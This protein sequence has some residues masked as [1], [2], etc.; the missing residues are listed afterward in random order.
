MQLVGNIIFQK[1]FELSELNRDAKPHK[2]SR[3]AVDLKSM[4]EEDPA[5]IYQVR[6]GYKQ[7]YS[8]YNCN[9]NNSGDANAETNIAVLQNDDPDAPIESFWNN[10]VSHYE[11]YTWEHRKDPCFPAYYHAGNFARRNILASNIGMLAKRGN[12]GSLQIIVND[13]RSTQSIAEVN[14]TLYDFAQQKIG[15]ALTN[16]QGV[17]KFDIKKEPFVAVAYFQQ[18]RGYLKIQDGGN[19]SLSRFDV[20]GVAPQKGMKGYIYGERGVWRPGDSLYLNF[21]LEDKTGRLPADH[22]VSFKLKD[23]RG[24][25]QKS[26]VSSTNVK[27]VYPLH[28]ATSTEDP[29]GNWLA[30]VELGGATFTKS[31]KI[32][33]VKPNRLKIKLDFGKETLGP[34]DQNLS[35]DLQV[36]WLHGAPAKNLKA[37]IESKMKSIKTTFPTYSSFVFDDPAR[38]FD[39]E[40]KVIFDGT[41]NDK[42]TAPISTKLHQNTVAP[43]KLKIA[44][45]SRA[46]EQGGDFS[47]DNF[48]M[49]YSPY[50]RYAG[51]E[52]PVNQ[53]NSKRLDFGK[54]QSVD[55]VVVDSDGRPISNANLDVGLYRVEWRW[56]WDRDNNSENTQYNAADHKGSLVRKSVSTNSK[57]IAKF[58]FKVDDWGRYLIRACDDESG[59]CTG[60][61]FYAGYPWYDDDDNG[62]REAAAML[63]F[64]AGKKTYQMGEDIEIKIP[65]SENSRCLISI[66]NGTKVLK[67]IWKDAKAGDNIFKIPTTVDMTPNIYVNVTLLQA[68]GQNKND[69]GI[70]MYG[71][72][73]ITV[74][75]PA[76]KLDPKIQMPDVLEPKGKFT[77]KVSENNGQPMTYTVAVV[78]EGLLD[79]TRFK[80]PNPWN[81]FYAREALGVNTWDMYDLVLGAYGGDLKNILSIGG[82]GEVIDPNAAKK[83]NRFK[84]VVRHLGPFYLPAGE[85]ASHEITMPNY[86][87]SVRTMVVASGDLAY[88]KTEK[89]TAVK[90]PLMILATLPRVLGPTESLNLPVNVFAMEKHVKNVKISIKEL[91]GLGRFSGGTSQQL[92][93]N[94]IGDQIANFSLD[95]A[96][97]TGPAKFLVTATS[98]GESASQEIEI[99]IR[100]PNPPVTN[101]YDGTIAVGKNWEQSY[102]LAGMKGTNETILEVSGIPPLN[103]GK[104]LGYLLRYPHGCIEQTTSAAFPQL[105]VGK[106]L[107]MSTDDQDRAA[108]NIKAAISKINRYRRTDGSFSYWPGGSYYSDFGSNYAGHFLL[109]AQKAGYSV[110]ANLIADWRKSATKYARNWRFEAKENR[111]Y[112]RASNTLN[113]AY[114]LYTLALSGHPEWGAMNRLQEM[115]NLPTVA[116]WRL[117]LAYAEG[118]KPEIAKGLIRGLSKEVDAYQELGGSYGSEVRDEAMILETLV[119]INDKEA[120]AAVVR[121]LSENLSTDRWYST[122]TTAY[123]LLAIA[124]FV[125][126]NEVGKEIKFEYSLDGSPMVSAGSNSPIF[127]IALAEAGSKQSVKVVNSGRNLLFVRILQT[128]QPT[129]GDPTAVEKNLKMSIAYESMDGKKID[130]SRIEQGTDF[131]AKVKITHPGTRGIHYEEMALSQIFPSGWEIQNARLDAVGQSTNSD[132][133]YQ[134]IR[135]DRVFTY[136]DLNKNKSQTYQVQLNAAY[137]GKYYL[138]TVNCEAMYDQTVQARVPGRWVE[139]VDVQVF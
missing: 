26:F 132:Y 38:K 67:T 20:A 72:I 111:R 139:V 47:T 95:V 73:P 129:V 124:K 114:R 56:W 90:K 110:P 10:Y 116:K 77:V 37:K 101:V 59:H 12:D 4:V 109:E 58:D 36:N 49:E 137:P 70:R 16:N 121:S 44:F 55:L 52:I 32:E 93:F 82:D 66:E 23:P 134:D 65:A 133:D 18:Q 21:V 62:M 2:K 22:P 51:I 88:G 40:P 29:T 75:N 115:N 127:Q 24:Q 87:G 138:P 34:E 80:T 11:G 103:L 91:S 128:G 33:T 119:A 79:L 46:F 83:A 35:A 7:S 68:H 106:L 28:V 54:D 42:G 1:R 50:S 120:A 19:L 86:V 123:S 97:R 6:V 57:G 84:P 118:G 53:Y 81:Q 131:M 69:L 5:A 108:L 15:T 113:Q 64:S 122:Q 3:Y 45:K 17:A 14:V 102:E 104:R 100:N 94:E 74:E 60:D 61:F 27:G 31:L 135:D 25:I 89:T 41:V 136:F 105:Y 99:E 8:I 112:Y 30:T 92:T 63:S 117:A 71:V 85:S 126:Q 98:G 130:P 125:G 48:T 9:E 39:A 107:E 76:T 43:G 78:D 96:D 13:L